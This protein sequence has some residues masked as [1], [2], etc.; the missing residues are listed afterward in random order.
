MY[1]NNVN[2]TSCT[3]LLGLLL[4]NILNL[5]DYSNKIYSTQPHIQ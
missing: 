3:K 4:N 1:E 2:E 5:A